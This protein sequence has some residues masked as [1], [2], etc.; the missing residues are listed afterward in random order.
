MRQTG[1]NV[2]F[3]LCISHQYM[4]GQYVEIDV[5][6][7][8]GGTSSGTMPKCS[9]VGV[10]STAAAAAS[11]R[12]F[13]SAE[14]DGSSRT[15]AQQHQ[16]QRSRRALRHEVRSISCDLLSMLLT[17]KMHSSAAEYACLASPSSSHRPVQPHLLHAVASR[18][19]LVSLE[20]VND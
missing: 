17:C 9:S 6:T 1:P 2:D 7:K 10:Y 8:I 15:C 5:Q 12:P 14:K 13:I 18:Q 3:H 19:G 20:G 4:N 16:R 11:S